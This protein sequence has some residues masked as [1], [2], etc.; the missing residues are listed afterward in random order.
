MKLSTKARYGF[1]ALAEL[2]AHHGEGA[3]A[4]KDIA[5]KQKISRAYL[6]N[7]FNSLKVAGLLMSRRGPGGGWIFTRSPDRIHLDEV[8]TALEGAMGVV[9][10]VDHPDLCTSVN[11]CP[12]REIYVEVSEAV[13]AVLHRYTIEDIHQ[14]RLE[15]DALDAAIDTSGDLCLSP[16]TR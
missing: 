13:R 12:T 6:E 8:L 4:L 7:L 10:C 5:A 16:R 1:R 15:L 11:A 9:P 2:A 3:V 14:R